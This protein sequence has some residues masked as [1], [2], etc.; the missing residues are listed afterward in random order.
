[1]L[2]ADVFN[3]VT[4]QKF[5]CDK[6]KKLFPFFVGLKST[7]VQVSRTG[8]RSFAI[9]LILQEFL[10][11]LAVESNVVKAFCEFFESYSCYQ[12]SMELIKS[13][14][15]AASPHQSLRDSF[16]SRGSLYFF[17]F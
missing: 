17:H 9:K 3:E 15:P 2:Q 6:I 13:Q 12:I 11:N 4:L 5:F 1:M 8:E 10:H 16:P 14:V 7:E